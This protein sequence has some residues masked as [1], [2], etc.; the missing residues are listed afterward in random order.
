LKPPSRWSRHGAT[1]PT[2]FQD[3]IEFLGHRFE[4]I[5]GRFDGVDRRFDAMQGQLDGNHREALGHFAEGSR[6]LERLDQEYVAVTPA[7]RRLER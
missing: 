2:E 5:A 4:A 6:R 1:S 7:L 3:L